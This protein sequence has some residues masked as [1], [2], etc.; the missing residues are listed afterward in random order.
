MRY[1]TH[2]LPVHLALTAGEAHDNR[3][4]SDLLSALLPQTML[5][6]DRGYDADSIRELASSPLRR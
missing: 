2:G 6:P 3:P 1:D 5:L 4:C